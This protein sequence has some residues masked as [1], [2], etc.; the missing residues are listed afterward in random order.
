LAQHRG[1][2]D[3]DNAGAY[4]VKEYYSE[5]SATDDGSWQHDKITLKPYNPAYNPIVITPEDADDFR[6]VG[7][8]VGILK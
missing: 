2:Y 1:F 3:E 4:S 5:K 6:I 7:S 8:F